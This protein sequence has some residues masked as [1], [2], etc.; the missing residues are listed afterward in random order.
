MNVESVIGHLR[1]VWR[2]EHIIADIR[3]NYLLGSLG[4]KA[5]AALFA[6]F[7]LLLFELAAYF[8]LVQ[9]WNAIISA[10]LLGVFNLLL[11]ATLLLFG[12]KRPLPR[13]LAL[14]SEV[15]NS[16]VAALQVEARALQA[17]ALG[18]F[19]HPWEAAL[20][21]LLP[22]LIPIVIRALKRSKAKDI[23]EES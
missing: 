22:R 2:T 6:A 1:S 12:L 15:Q 9:L 14:A 18:G 19:R 21:T 20:A 11:A 8:A 7:G 23:A 5:F 13:E 3:L 4:L 10:V 17:N 16:A